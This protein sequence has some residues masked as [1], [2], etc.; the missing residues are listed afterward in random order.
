VRAWEDMLN[1]R[2]AVSWGDYKKIVA[3]FAALLVA[4]ALTVAPPPASPP[5]GD[6]GD[7]LPVI[8]RRIAGSGATA[9]QAVVDIGGAKTLPLDVIDGFAAQVP[10]STLGQLRRS[11]GI[12][13]VTRDRQVKLQ[14]R[15]SSFDPVKDPGSMYNVGVS[16]GADALWNEGI[17]GQ[18]IDIAII[19]SGVVPVEGLLRPGKIVN[20]PDLSF[21][22]QD[23]DLRYLDTFGHGTH[24]TGIMAGADQGV[25]PGRSDPKNWEF[26]GIAPQARVVNVKVADA[27]GATDV[28]QV[29]AAI[30]WVVQHKNHRNLN[31]RVL[32]LSFGTDGTQDPNIDPL[33]YAAEVAWD[34]GIVVVVAAGNRGF[35]NTS[36]NNPALSPRLIAVGAADTMGTPDPTDDIVPEFSSSGDEVRNPDF[37]APGKSVVSLRD[38]GSFIDERFPE[39]AVGQRFF[40]GSGT[41]QAAAVVSGAVATLLQKRP[42]LTPDQVKALLVETAIPLPAG[43]PRAQGAGLINVAAAASASAP[44]VEPPAPDPV[45]PPPDPVEPPVPDPVEAPPDPVEPPAPPPPDPPADP[46]PP[47]DPTAPAPSPD[48]NATPAPAPA[49]TPTPDPVPTPEPDPTPTPTPEPAPAPPGSGTLEGARGTGHLISPDGE[50]LRGEQDIFGSPWNGVTWAEAARANQSWRGGRWNGVTWTGRE[51]ISDTRNWLS[52]RGIQWTRNSWSGDNWS[53]NS[54]SRNSWSNGTW[55]GEAWSRNSWSGDTWARHSWSSASWN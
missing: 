52:W 6:D 40:R 30:D 50:E 13:S 21:E 37:V 41:S 16:V 45:E 54:W 51:W 53:R 22:S 19:D 34:A 32:N 39:A 36:L 10:R 9:D 38:P 46:A 31:I 2:W 20:G 55:T 23:L 25:R 28:S 14:G 49:P 47:S 42:D 1:Q 26:S 43:D 44:P 18:G 27:I 15:A 5:I 24:M 33:S 35:G 4:V 12:H 8:V 48:P 17:G 3:G 11:P 7:L 29:I